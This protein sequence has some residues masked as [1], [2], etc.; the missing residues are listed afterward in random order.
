MAKFNFQ[1]LN[2]RIHLYTGLIMVPYIFIFGLSGLLF[3]HPTLMIDRSVE[4]FKLSDEDSFN[5]LFPDLEQL[6]TSIADS[7]VNDGLI[8]Q[9]TIG[10]VNYSNTLILRN[11]NKDADYRVQIDLPTS[12]VQLMTL[13]DFADNPEIASG[14]YNLGVSLNSDKLAKK[15]EQ[16]LTKQGI[17]P[18]NSRVQRVPDLI[19]DLNS[20]DTNYQVIYNLSNGNYRIVDLNKRKFKIN[21]FLTNIHQEH[22]YPI[23]GFSIKWLWVFFADSLSI[24]MI[25]WALSGIIMWFNMKKLLTIGTVL[26]AFSI[27][28][29]IIILINYYELG[30]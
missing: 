17:E 23:S 21:Y 5:K 12:N 8:S 14:N 24:L 25:V 6:A 1:K 22:G 9:P 3:N 2:R 19:F 4:S 29:S 16:I 11:L 20:K 15:L 10:A 30:F 7:I 27:L 18:G 26:L 28:V 13:P